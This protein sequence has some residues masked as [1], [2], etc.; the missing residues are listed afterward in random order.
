MNDTVEALPV[1][2]TNS[3][4]EKVEKVDNKTEEAI[5]DP[6]VDETGV[7]TVTINT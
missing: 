7:P 6:E 5:E 3:T 4:I 1:N 2:A